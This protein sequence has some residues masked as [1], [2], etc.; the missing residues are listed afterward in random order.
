M[1]YMVKANKI[2]LYLEK[3]NWKEMPVLMPG[4]LS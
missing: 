1:T 4:C 3:H 2:Q